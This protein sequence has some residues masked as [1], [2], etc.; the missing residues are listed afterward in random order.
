M[1]VPV[2]VLASGAGSLLSALLDEAARHG[3]AFEVVAVAVDREC[4]AADLA[5]QQGIVVI[6]CRLAD[7]LIEA[8]G[9]V[10]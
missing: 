1:T 2:V 5:A 4:R 8:R 9:T 6:T 10:R 3:A 7:Y